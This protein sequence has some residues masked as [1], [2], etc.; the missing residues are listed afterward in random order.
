MSGAS[1][2]YSSLPSTKGKVVLKTS[3]GDIEIELFSKQTPLTC[4]NF[5]QLCLEKYYVGCDFF[6]IVKDFMIQSGDPTNTG[7][8]GE[9]A[10]GKD[11]GP[12][13]DEFHGR[14]RFSER[15]L[16]AM[17]NAEADDNRSQFFITLNKAPF[18]N[19]KNAIFGVISTRTW[20]TVQRIGMGE[21]DGERPL[22]PF[23]IKDCVVLVNPFDD[24]EPRADKLAAKEA[25]IRGEET[26]QATED[27]KKKKRSTKK[28]VK[29]RK[30]L[31]FGD[32]FGDDE[33]DEMAD[34][35][36]PAKKPRKLGANTKLVQ[37]AEKPK[38]PKSK[39]KKTA[40][41][42][43]V[44]AA[45]PV[46]SATSVPAETTKPVEPAREFSQ[47]KKKEKKEKVEPS[48]AVKEKLRKRREEMEQ[49]KK[50]AQEGTSSTMSLLKAFR[51]RMRSNRQA[52]KE[53][54]R[55]STGEEEDESKKGTIDASTGIMD[56]VSDSDSDEDTTD[57]I[58]TQIQFKKRPQDYA[59][60]QEEFL[61]NYKVLD[62]AGDRLRRLGKDVH[63]HSTPADPR[64]S[65]DRSDRRR[66][67]SRSHD[68][69]R[70][71]RSRDRD[72]RSRRRRSHSR[73][74]SRSRGRRR[75]SYRR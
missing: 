42:P 45:E 5:V 39:P 34:F 13:Y 23:T 12:F 35:K 11:G 52:A 21:C 31:A 49:M 54:Q 59:A 72:R 7:K 58:G 56:V 75:S 47:K 40:S 68:R 16:V 19:R 25:Q 50:Q 33:E 32:D 69:R 9:S 24:C 60:E 17:A 74:R 55:E 64:P 27:Q 36:R 22:F 67:R 3:A 2:V 18:L 41:R 26:K 15:G 29:N 10:V 66:R 65:G 63:S 14:L 61:R 1:G 62:E 73:S 30:L 46:R 6:R 28:G 70:R 71:S 4:R 53:K 38:T 37:E 51:D 48:A 8:G 20:Y 43:T 57:F 44:Q